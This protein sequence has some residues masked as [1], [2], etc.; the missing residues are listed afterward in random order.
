M[1]MIVNTTMIIHRLLY[2]ISRPLTDLGKIN[3][4]DGNQILV[5]DLIVS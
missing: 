1:L 3:T 2:S 5:V 4:S